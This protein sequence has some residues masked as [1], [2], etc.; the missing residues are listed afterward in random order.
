MSI[1][2]LTGG[3]L[4]GV[5]VLVVEDEPETLDL[6]ALTLKSAGAEVETASG[7]EAALA[8]LGPPAPDVVVSDLQMPGLDGYALMRRLQELPDPPVAIAL[9]ASASL[10]DAR[11][12]LEAGFRVHVAKPVAMLDLVEAI[13][14]LVP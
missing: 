6:I 8:R 4:K 11:R 14:A 13:R 1:A 7:A 2:E 12:A 10:D 3:E 9:S 5:R